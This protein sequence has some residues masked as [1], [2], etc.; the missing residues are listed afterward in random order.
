MMKLTKDL[1]IL[2]ADSFFNIIVDLVQEL[3]REVGTNWLRTII[4][5]RLMLQMDL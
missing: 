2:R 5:V 3:K 4:Q 1:R